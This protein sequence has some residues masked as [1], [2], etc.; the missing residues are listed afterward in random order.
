MLKNIL[1]Y[2]PFT[3]YVTPLEG[4]GSLDLLQSVAE[5][6]RSGE[7]YIVPLRNA[8]EFSG[9]PF[10]SSAFFYWSK[11][12]FWRIHSQEILRKHGHV[13]FINMPYLS[14]AIRIFEGVRSIY[15]SLS[16]GLPFPNLSLFHLTAG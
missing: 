15:V 8:E 2:G 9:Q 12:S 3:R 1:S 4:G 7:V 16:F 11:L 14:F 5:R 13:S 6:K 10:S